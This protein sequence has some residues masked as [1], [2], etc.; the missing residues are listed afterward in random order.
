MDDDAQQTTAPAPLPTNTTAMKDPKSHLTDEKEENNWCHRRPSRTSMHQEEATIWSQ[1]RIK[2]LYAVVVPAAIVYLL[3]YFDRQ[4]Q[5]RHQHNGYHP[6]QR[7]H[8]YR[9]MPT[10]AEHQ[11]RHWEEHIMTQPPMVEDRTLVSKYSFDVNERGFGAQLAHLYQRRLDFVNRGFSGY[12]SEQAI[13]LLPQFLPKKASLADPTTPRVQFLTIYFGTNDSC[14]PDSVQHVKLEKY[15]ANIRSLID[16]VHHPDSPT[17]S[18][19]TRILLIC[20]GRL[21]EPKWTL[22]RQAQG[23]PMDRSAAM[24]EQYVERC[25]AIGQEYHAKSEKEGS[26]LHRVHVVDTWALMTEQIDS[27]KRILADYVHDGV[28]LASAGN[29]LIF[30]EIMRIIQTHYPEWDPEKMPM[31]AP[32]WGDLDPS[33]LENQLLIG[34][35]KRTK[36]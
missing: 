27:G 5:Y 6:Q 36:V 14:L 22:H 12:N 23:R 31:H 34:A 30:Q 28:H 32:W 1:W 29:D 18:P 17:Y 24:T 13:H 35:N 9:P 10:G 4:H 3:L 33:N 20:P 25:R 7:H 11:G 19:E 2:L 8:P 26:K 16:M 15:E 21:D